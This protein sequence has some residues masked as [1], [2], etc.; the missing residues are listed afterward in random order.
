MLEPLVLSNYSVTLRSVALE[1]IEQLRLWRNSEHV[2]RFMLSDESIS[3]EQQKAWFEHIQRAQNQYHFVIDYKGEP[4]GS[5]NIKTRGHEPNIK[6]AHHFECGLYIGNPK[7][8]GNIIAFAP[9]LVMND[10]CFDTLNATRL[11]AVV[12]PD[13]VAALRYNEKLGYEIVS[14]GS[15]IEIELTRENYEGRSAKLKQFFNR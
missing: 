6:R 9:T 4:I 13:N 14:R 12:K 7:F 10:Y 11:H 15:L 3:V 2:R 1:D 8:I 5:C